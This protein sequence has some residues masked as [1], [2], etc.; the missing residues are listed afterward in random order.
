[1]SAFTCATYDAEMRGRTWTS[2]IAIASAASLACAC[3]N[4]GNVFSMAA[5]SVFLKFLPMLPTQILLNSFLY[6]LAQVP[7]PGDNVDAG[8]VQRPQRWDMKVIGDFMV[9]LGPI[10]S[11]FDFVTFFVLL[12]SSTRARR[13][14][15]RA[16][17]SNRSQRRRWCCSSFERWATRFTA[18]RAVR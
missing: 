14:F 10:S 6:D 3:S 15:A 7:I 11:I 13:C 2:F 16:G 9:V 8:Y 4:F 17:S 5:A 1:V 18:G 12:R